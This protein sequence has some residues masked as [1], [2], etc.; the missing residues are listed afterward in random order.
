[1]V[2]IAQVNQTKDTKVKMLITQLA[3]VIILLAIGY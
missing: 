1:M 3:K 2:R